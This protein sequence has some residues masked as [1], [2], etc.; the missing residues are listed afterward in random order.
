M[1]ICVNVFSMVF[2]V[3]FIDFS[4]RLL[5]PHFLFV[6]L[7]TSSKSGGVASQQMLWVTNGKPFKNDD[8][9]AKHVCNHA[10]CVHSRNKTLDSH[11]LTPSPPCPAIANEECHGRSF[12]G[13]RWDE[14]ANLAHSTLQQIH[15]GVQRG[16]TAFHLHIQITMSF[17][18]KKNQWR[19]M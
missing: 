14:S 13:A 11:H 17:D 5:T 7:G 10:T 1:W 4:T 12:F 9:P 16:V 19:N 18:T 8:M 3:F 15:G 2:H 6:D